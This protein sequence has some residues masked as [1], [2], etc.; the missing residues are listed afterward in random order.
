[1]DFREYIQRYKNYFY[2]AELLGL[3]HDIG[4]S[5]KQFVE[6]AKTKNGEPDKA[7]TLRELFSEDFI[8]HI[9]NFVNSILKSID[10]PI[11]NVIQQG[12][13][14]EILINHHNSNVI[15]KLAENNYIADVVFSPGCDGIDSGFDKGN[16][17]NSG[18][19]EKGFF[20]INFAGKKKI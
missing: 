10:N 14:M 19:Q 7:H 16:V 15:S 8:N 9:D 2:V 1:M 3:L 18:V 17:S 4:K 5:S 20:A 13:F 6:A 11:D 12:K